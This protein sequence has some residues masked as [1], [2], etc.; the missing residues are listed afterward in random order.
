MKVVM[1]LILRRRVPATELQGC[2]QDFRTAYVGDQERYRVGNADRPRRRDGAF[3]AGTSAG[4]KRS[5]M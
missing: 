1:A 5:A 4:D 2:R 3:G